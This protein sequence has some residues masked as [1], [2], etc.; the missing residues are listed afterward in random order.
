MQDRKFQKQPSLSQTKS[1]K[2]RQILKL[3]KAKDCK[4]VVLKILRRN[5]LK[6]SN[7]LEIDAGWN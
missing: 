6:M 3:I 4:N 7:N 1:N 5:A 2:G